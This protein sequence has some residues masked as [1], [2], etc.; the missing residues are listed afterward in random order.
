MFDDVVIITINGQDW[1]VPANL[2]QYITA[3]GINSGS[4]T[5]TG[6]QSLAYSTSSRYPRITFNSLSNPVVYTSAQNYQ[7]LQDPQVV[8]SNAAYY[9]KALV[10]APILEL[11]LT[12]LIFIFVAFRRFSR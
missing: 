5:I 3:D 11:F 9:Q 8:F 7:I 12:G 10:Y 4:T 6:Y 1:Y 2:V